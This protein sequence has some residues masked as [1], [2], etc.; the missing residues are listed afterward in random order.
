MVLLAPSEADAF[1]VFPN[2]VKLEPC[3]VSGCPVDVERTLREAPR[4]NAAPGFVSLADGLQVGVEPGFAQA[5]VDGVPASGIPLSVGEVQQGLVDAFSAWETRELGFDITFGG[6]FSS[7]IQVY[8]VDGG[9]HPFFQGNG[10][11]GV[12]SVSAFPNPLTLT[13]GERLFGTVIENAEIY[14]APDR[15]WQGFGLWILAGLLTEEDRLERFV[16]LM[17]HEIGHTLG[18]HH[19]NEFPQ[20]NFD[21][22]GDPFTVV[23]P[24]NPLAPWEGLAISTN[25]DP[26]SVMRG[27]IPIDFASFAA[28]E[29]YADD[30]S[31]L[32]VLYPSVPEPGAVWLVASAVLHL[33]ARR[34]R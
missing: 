8:A 16:N 33:A 29:L 17:I 1:T 6:S 7:E 10:F 3:G 11:S 25:V 2:H 14:V 19:L 26:N 5:I 15:L 18:L 12:A 22:D 21:D 28:T 27:G 4:W 34:R 24:G 32:N 23:H 31:G 20:F 13:S 30:R 9:T